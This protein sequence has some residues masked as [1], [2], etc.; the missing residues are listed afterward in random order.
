MKFFIKKVINSLI[1]HWH[2]PH[3]NW[4]KTLFFNFMTLPFKEAMRLPVVIY[5]P[6]SIGSIMGQ[7]KLKS[8]VHYGMLKIGLSDQ[9]RSRHSKSYISIDGILEIDEDTTLR[10]GI[11]LQIREN[12]ILRLCKSAYIGDNNTIITECFIEI[13]HSVRIGN[14]TTFMDTDFHYIINTKNREVKYNKKPIVIGENCWIGGWCTIKKGTKLPKGTIVAGP[15]SMTS[16]DYTNK[17]A[18]CSLIAGSPAKV[19][20]EGMRRI[21]NKQSDKEIVKY[22][23][24]NEGIFVLQQDRNLDDFCMPNE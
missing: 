23:K 24:D 13:G 9:V 22:Y 15:Y 11:H 4:I 2:A 7:V 14:N 20:V 10:K 17:I 18:E 21:N 1:Y 6:C 19:L 8:T 16:K 5:G 12:G 3:V